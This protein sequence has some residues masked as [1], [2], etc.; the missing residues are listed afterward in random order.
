[1]PR[2]KR[3]IERCKGCGG[4]LDRHFRSLLNHLEASEECAL[5]YQEEGIVMKDLD[6]P[7]QLQYVAEA[8]Q[9]LGIRRR[10]DD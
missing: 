3:P 8:K 6:A 7:G 5:L 4:R 1:M 10:V 2:R 9:R